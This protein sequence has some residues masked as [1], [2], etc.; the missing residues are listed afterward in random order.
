M[1]GKTLKELLSK[2][3][4]PEK[5]LGVLTTA[6]NVVSRVDKEKRILEV[7]ADFPTLVDKE[8][9]YDIEKQVT[10]VYDLRYFKILPRYDSSLFSYEYIPQI[11][12]ETEAVG[13]VARGFFSDYTYLIEDGKLTIKIPFN[14]NGLNL[15]E[16]AKTPAVIENIIK[17]EFDIQIKV[18]LEYSG[19]INTESSES[20]RLRLEEIDRQLAVAEKYYEEH[21]HSNEYQSKAPDK[22]EENDE[23]K[24]PRVSSI[25]NYDLRECAVDGEKIKIGPSIFELH[26]PNFVIGEEF[27]VRPVPIATINK[28]VK[29]IVFVGDVFAFSSEPNRAG[30]KFNVSI[31]IFD[32]NSSIYAKR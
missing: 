23:L 26:E 8:I 11:L 25:Y 19:T 32:G 21:L 1:A 30:D 20:T 2:Y 14:E 29:N 27:D 7:R 3:I 6:D 28:P 18:S 15:L 17:S 4:A 12:K 10:Q 9:L 31:G 22:N 13:V 24:L 16:D 5:Y